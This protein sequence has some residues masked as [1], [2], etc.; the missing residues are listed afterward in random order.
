MA[1]L[2]QLFVSFFKIGSLAFGGGWAIL[3]LIEHEVV[4]VNHWLDGD[5]F[6]QIVYVSGFTPGPIAVSGSALIGQKVAGIPGAIAAVLGIVIPSALFPML[7]FYFLLKYGEN[8]HV[9]GTIKALGPVAVAMIAY[10]GYSLGKG[11]FVKADWILITIAAVSFAALY[12][13]VNPFLVVVGG[14][15]IGAIFLS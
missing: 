6:R 9:K 1:T 12:F 3:T 5:Q 7:L 13:K 4:N 14:A 15:I 11:V 2:V 8:N 10:A